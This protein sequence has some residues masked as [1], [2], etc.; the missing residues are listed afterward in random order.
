MALFKIQQC[1][2]CRHFMAL[3]FFFLQSILSLD[4]EMERIIGIKVVIQGSI[5]VN[6]VMF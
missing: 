6:N 2:L 3:S 1:L 4:M 5:S